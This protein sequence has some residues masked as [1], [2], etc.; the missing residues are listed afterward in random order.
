[1]GF[2]TDLAVEA[3]ERAGALPG[4]TQEERECDGVKVVEVTVREGEGA[5]KLN[6]S[7]GRYI[8]I[9]TDAI[10]NGDR[11]GERTAAEALSRELR[12]LAGEN[13]KSVLVV[14]LG[15]RQITADSLGPAVCDRVFVTR[16]IRQMAPEAIDSR[17]NDVG[18][19]SPGVLGVTGVETGEIVC[20]ITERI[21]P[22][23]IVAIDSL[24]SG[25]VERIRTTFQLTDTGISPGSGLGGGRTALDRSTLG[26]P[27]IA[28][29]VPLVVYAS[30]IAEELLSHTLSEDSSEY[31]RLVESVSQTAG[32]ELVVT[33]KDID[34]IV[35]ACA[36]VI[37]DALNLGLHNGITLEE[38]A[39]LMS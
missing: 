13:L 38:V 22:T 39:Q 2:R 6:R 3:H 34:F 25:S 37:S 23:L 33:P 20:G 27:V 30:S 31:Q 19:V 16:H 18:A 35:D 15:N 1:M 5:K 29:G 36:R 28:I 8:T 4:V 11:Q 21:S 9:E 10:A 12:S 17:V 32:A 24:A 14:G 26:I 7:P